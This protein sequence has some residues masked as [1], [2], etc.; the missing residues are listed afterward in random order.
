MTAGRDPL[1]RLRDAAG[2][3]AAAGLRR[4]LRPRP[5]GLTDLAS[6][7]YLGLAG[8]PRLV[9][10]AVAAAREWGTGSTG[11]RLVTGTTELHAELDRRLAAFTGSAAGLVFSSG[12]L[13]NLGAVTALAGPDTLVV[14]DQVN[15][16]SIVDAC[17]LSRSR[18][19]IVPHGDAAAAERA[20]AEREEDH[21][22]VVTDAVFSVDGDVAPLGA[23]HAAVRA[24]GALLVVDEAHALGV[25]G[26]G[27]R[28][29]AH[30]AGLAGE[31]DVV[32]TLT[33]SKSLASQG[34]A[35]LGA[36]E[37]IDT[38]VDTGRSFIFDT[39]L[40]PPAAGAALAALDVLRSDPDLP[41]RARERALAISNLAAGSGLETA[42][43]AAAVV[44]VFLGEPQA[45]VRA[46]GICAEHG[47][48]VGCFR[49]PS[50]PKGRACL[51][52]TARATLDESDLTRL[53]AA[54]AEIAS[55]TGRS[56]HP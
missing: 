56:L 48:R 41:G 13:A 55:S 31:P 50:V 37:V 40:N 43:P 32:L 9:E 6:N 5:D 25:V 18:V 29:A 2:R 30:A 7:D 44:P 51:R 21:A 1:A 3:R 26:D 27:G 45:A 49:P 47:L 4:S 42:R 20:L 35:V 19:V 15:H 22:L 10:G 12:F 33:L 53:R 39:G 23:L 14:S 11:S 28:G 8:D 16:A 36:P 46:A 52:L 54:L 24:H 34:G 17:R 38:L